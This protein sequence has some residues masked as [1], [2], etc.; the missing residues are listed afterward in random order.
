MKI[1]LSLQGKY[2]NPTLASLACVLATSP[3]LWS[4]TMT[5]SALQKEEFMRA[6]GSRRHGCRLLGQEADRSPSTRRKDRK[7][8]EMQG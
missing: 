5:R 4:N 2:M 8:E 3:W 1:S 6:Q 7:L